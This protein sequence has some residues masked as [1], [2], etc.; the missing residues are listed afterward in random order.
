M[1]LL[2]KAL[3]L[4]NFKVF[5][6]VNRVEITDGPGNVVVVQGDNGRGKSTLMESVFWA[7]YGKEKRHDRLVP[8]NYPGLINN[9]AKRE[10][11]YHA[12][13]RVTFEH[14][15]KLFEV[16]RSVRGRDGVAEPS[17][18][19]D[20]EETLSF[21]VDGKDL[22]SDNSLLYDVFPED[23]AS[24][25]FFDGETISRYA[26][27]QAN[28]RE[29]VEKALGLPFLRQAREDIE[30]VRKEFEKE[31]RDVQ[32]SP[33][34]EKTEA[35]LKELRARAAQQVAQLNEEEERL[36]ALNRDIRGL[37]H[38]LEEFDDLRGIQSRIQELEEFS[39]ELDKEEAGILSAEAA[40]KA[41]LPW[42][43]LGKSV[44]GA[45]DLVGKIKEQAVEE[46]IEQGR[47]MDQL[48]FMR[49]LKA[50]GVCICGGRLEADALA[51][52]DDMIGK[53]NQ[54]LGTIKVIETDRFSWTQ[55]D[56]TTALSKARA[57][58]EEREN[59][60]RLEAK[61]RY[62]DDNRQRVARALERE[63]EALRT[64]SAQNL[65][66]KEVF[67]RLTQL[68]KEKA[69]CQARIEETRTALNLTR[70]QVQELERQLEI[71]LSKKSAAS[72]SLLEAISRS[73]RVLKALEEI[74][75]RSAEQRRAEIER[76]ASSIYTSITNK[77]LEFIGL[78]IDPETFEVRVREQ[79]GGLIESK[80][81]SDGER[82]VLAL[83]FLGGLKDST[84]EGTL[85]MD[86][87][88]GRLDQTH[89]T[90]LIQKIPELAKNVVLL[91]TD[92]DLRPEDW[93]SLS[94]VQR[95]FT[96][97]HDQLQKFSTIQ[98]VR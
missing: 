74:I 89:K 75:D 35:E 93:K 17:R 71:S 68:T 16:E 78:S 80:K 85:I 64:H 34:M 79:G 82:H 38:N 18:R 87:P 27:A 32:S 4:E 15:G 2:I 96:L 61:R 39:A 23:V 28:N 41:E 90:R 88:F 29:T 12:R 56:L 54:A 69:V 94:S 25:F 63:R 77:P 7:L 59:V 22:G 86:S 24:F 66:E 26:E 65:R 73:G 20:F 44:R 81:L 19:S 13:V 84:H 10:G 57:V 1:E 52:I 33:E 58:E 91:V 83:S 53:I 76:R 70:R 5:H 14:D 97:E 3:E 43:I 21:R 49:D 47:L 72:R 55:G 36:E 48:E 62:L 37:Q 11:R 50:S 9:T 6:G 31:L 60:H 92:E 51:H 95:R 30:R 45:V 40:F 67:D 42:L 98:E 46:R 8:A